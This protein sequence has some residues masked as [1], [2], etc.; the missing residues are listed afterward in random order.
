VKAR[1]D[2]LE[3]ERLARAVTDDET[4]DRVLSAAQSASLPRGQSR[5]RL[6]VDDLLLPTA[7]LTAGTLRLALREAPIV[8]VVLIA[9]FVTSESWQFFGRLDGIHYAKV[10]AGFAVVIAVVLA[11]AI[12]DELKR[13]ATIPDDEP[14]PSELDAP[15]AEAG[16]GPPPG[17]L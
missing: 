11:F 5:L 6:P 2:L 8:V 12:A 4:V 1:R 14:P 7:R 9:V 17:G 15:L 10:L 13:A 3:R 16:F